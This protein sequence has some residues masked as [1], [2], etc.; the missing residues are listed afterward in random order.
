MGVQIV[1][2]QLIFE[3]NEEI[4]LAS[5]DAKRREQMAEVSVE[6]YT[7]LL[8]S[9][10]PAPGGGGAAALSAAQGY[11]LGSMVIRFTI[12]KPKFA[13]H[14]AR[15]KELLHTCSLQA[16][17]LLTLIDLDEEYFLP[18]S[19]AYGIKAET[20]EEKRDKERV[21]NEA[22]GTACRA[23]LEIMKLSLDGLLLLE[24]LRHISSAM[25]VS[26]VGVGAQLL[27]AAVLS[28]ELN[29]RINLKTLTNDPLRIEMAE[30]AEQ[31]I[32]HAQE[33]HAQIMEYVQGKLS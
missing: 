33:L 23:P 10:L 18:L 13:P 26:D 32:A 12:G 4:A 11:A 20:E 15:L 14:E 28:A 6:E 3:P 19:R 9:K 22:L 31:T 2:N 27:Y 5:C 7:A 21:M 24:E 29:V 30:Y 17:R 25:V 8:A 1:E 16:K